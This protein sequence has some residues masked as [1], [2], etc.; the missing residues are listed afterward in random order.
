MGTGWEVRCGFD[1]GGIVMMVEMVYKAEDAQGQ[2][3]VRWAKRLAVVLAVVL[4]GAL[5]GALDGALDE[6]LGRAL[7]GALDGQAD[8]AD[9][10]ESF[11]MAL[12]INAHH[13]LV[14]RNTVTRLPA[15]QLY[16]D[17]HGTVLY[18]TVV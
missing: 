12:V 11:G 7:D 8:G 9:C 2:V 5:A 17:E 16:C 3:K 14:S 15:P 10:K 6:A 18:C 1:A 4:A 13:T